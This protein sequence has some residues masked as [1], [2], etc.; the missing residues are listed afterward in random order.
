[1]FRPRSAF[2]RAC[3]FLPPETAPCL[4]CPPPVPSRPSR[5]APVS[6]RLSADGG[7]GASG[8]RLVPEGCGGVSGAG[9]GA[10][11]AR[12]PRVG[13]SPRRPAGGCRP[14]VTADSLSLSQLRVTT[15]RD[16]RPAPPA[17]LAPLT[18]RGRWRGAA[19]DPRQPRAP[20]GR[21]H[22]RP[23]GATQTASSQAHTHS[24]TARVCG[25]GREC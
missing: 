12:P 20:P 25:A 24:L 8:A 16:Q 7:H 15:G 17:N 1:M 14:L 23:D 22:Q 9:A 11:P 13:R 18:V 10:D 3:Y 21:C 4:P 6:P 2:Q 19:A 5:H